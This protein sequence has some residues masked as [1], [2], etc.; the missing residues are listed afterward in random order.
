MNRGGEG[1]R[2]LLLPHHL[3]PTLGLS[4]A[5]MGGPG[6]QPWVHRMIGG[7][8][9]AHLWEMHIESWLDTNGSL[10]CS[11]IEHKAVD[12]GLFQRRA[13]PA[14]A[15]RSSSS[16]WRCDSPQLRGKMWLLC[17]RQRKQGSEGEGEQ[18]QAGCQPAT[19][20]WV[21]LLG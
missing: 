9:E 13:R 4:G 21:V 15:R 5:C 3:S 12:L 14:P 18:V 6:S 1:M 10:C 8:A 2:W 16:C 20:A 17:L 19:D 11:L 7:A